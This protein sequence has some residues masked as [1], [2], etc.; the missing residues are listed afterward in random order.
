M[1]IGELAKRTGMAAS[2]IRFYESRGLLKVANR[3]SNG[4]R[5][6]PEEAVTILTIIIDAQQAGFSLDEIKQ[7]LPADVSAWQHDELIAIL[8]RKVTDIEALLTKL[9]QNKAHLQQLIQLIESKPEDMDCKLNA[10][11]VMASL[12]L[13]QEH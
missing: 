10:A 11:R 2:A 4:Y 13:N 1:K 7:L 6:Y 3:Q 8:Q 12:G 5:D 9:T